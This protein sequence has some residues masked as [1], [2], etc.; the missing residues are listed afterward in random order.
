MSC[1]VML[2]YVISCVVML[3][4]VKLCYVMLCQVM[5]CYVML[6]YVMLCHT[7][8]CNIILHNMKCYCITYLNDD[9]VMVC[10]AM[11]F[12]ITQCDN[13]IR[14]ILTYTLMTRHKLWII[15]FY[16]NQILLDYLYMITVY[17]MFKCGCLRFI[18]NRQTN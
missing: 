11:S 7:M 1:Y 17:V 14:L 15:H 10:C 18:F 9:D 8:P 2:C 12:N 4:Y 5:L 6:C 3:C 16:G 13:I